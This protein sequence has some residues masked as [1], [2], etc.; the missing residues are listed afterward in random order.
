MLDTNETRNIKSHPT[1]QPLPEIPQDPYGQPIEPQI[2]QVLPESKPWYKSKTLMLNSIVAVVGLAT[3]ATPYIEPF[4]STETFGL[5]MAGIGFA[6]AALRF[7]T[8]KGLTK[9]G[10]R[11]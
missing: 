5:V 8:K 3:S 11:G 4:V 9:G 2:G 6:N 1:E 7:A 10:N